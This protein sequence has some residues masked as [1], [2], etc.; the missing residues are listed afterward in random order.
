MRRMAT[1]NIILRDELLTD[2]L[3][4]G[5]ASKNDQQCADDLNTKY[6]QVVESLP[7]EKLILWSAEAGRIQ[8]IETAMSN[9][10]GNVNLRAAARAFYLTIQAFDAADPRDNRWVA[11]VDGLVA[12]AVLTAADKAALVAEATVPRSR[13]EELGL[14]T[15]QAGEVREARFQ[16]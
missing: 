15:V 13:A 1:M 5:Y 9:T 8:K 14:G 6:R 12:G 11:L 16:G 2:P 4:R 7:P 10:G 3:G